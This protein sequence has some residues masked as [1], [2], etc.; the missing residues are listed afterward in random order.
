M[1]A[2]KR[3]GFALHRYTDAK[4]DVANHQDEL[5]A[6]CSYRKQSSASD[7]SFSKS[8]RSSDLIER[9]VMMEKLFLT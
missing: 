5:K 6:T 4:Q 2:G 1:C 7:K 3:A 8:V 9:N